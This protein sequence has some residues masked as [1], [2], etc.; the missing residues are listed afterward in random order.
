MEQS[1]NSTSQ[2]RDLITISSTTSTNVINPVAKSSGN[3]DRYGSNFSKLV[4]SNTSK[5]SDFDASLPDI[6]DNLF[7]LDSV[8]NFDV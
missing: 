6:S 8:R 5:I 4:Y 7:G 3:L 1:N 2:T